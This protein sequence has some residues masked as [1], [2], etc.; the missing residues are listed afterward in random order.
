MYCAHLLTSDAILQRTGKPSPP[1]E[2]LCRSGTTKSI[3]FLQVIICLCSQ[4]LFLLT[5]S[6]NRTAQQSIKKISLFAALIP[7]VVISSS[8][9]MCVNF[10]F[11]GTCQTVI[12]NLIDCYQLWHFHR[13]HC[14]LSLYYNRP[15]I[16]GAGLQED[17]GMHDSLNKALVDSVL[18]S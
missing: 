6:G 11:R 10:S 12:L 13:S 9:R 7:T 14:A 16:A 1:S 18:A 2:G 5:M 8:L 3:L 17:Q 4:P 15:T